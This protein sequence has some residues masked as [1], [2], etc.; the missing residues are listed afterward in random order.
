MAINFLSSSA[1]NISG[2]FIG[3]PEQ[4]AFCSFNGFMTQVFVIQTDYWVLVIAVCT[5]FILADYKQLS[6][7]VQDHR[8]LLSCLPWG[9]SVLWAA[10][11]LAVA[12]YG[13]IGACKSSSDNVTMH[14]AGC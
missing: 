3:D 12:G 1:M 9:F 14:V 8:I 11:G 10:I 13:N 7:W 5:F 6:C 4:K 2:R